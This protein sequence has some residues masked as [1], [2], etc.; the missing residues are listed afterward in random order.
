MCKWTMRVAEQSEWA[1]LP[2]LVV[3]RVLKQLQW[4][5]SASA[6]FRK[7]C[8]RWQEV[9]DGL[10][11]GLRV[12]SVPEAWRLGRRLGGVRKLDMRSCVGVSD[13]TI[14]TLASITHLTDLELY[15]CK[16][17]D[18]HIRM[19]AP[20]LINLAHL[21]LSNCTTVT[22]EG[23]RALSPLSS[24]KSLS[25]ANCEEV[26]DEG[27]RAIAFSHAA[28]TRL[29]LANCKAITTD[30]LRALATLTTLGKLDLSFRKVTVEDLAV[31]AL[32]HSLTSLDLFACRVETCQGKPAAALTPLHSLTGLN[33]SC[34]REL[35]DEGLK[36]LVVFFPALTQLR[37]DGCSAVTSSGVKALTTLSSL[38]TLNLSHCRA[39]SEAGVGL[40]A[41]C[42]G[43][44]SLDLVSSCWN[45]GDCKNM[46]A[47]ASLTNLTALNLQKCC[48]AFTYEGMRA[49]ASL[50]SLTSL[51]LS[52][53]LP[54]LEIIERRNKCKTV[55]CGELRVFG[56]DMK[57]SNEATLPPVTKLTCVDNSRRTMVQYSHGLGALMDKGI[58][59]FSGCR[60]AAEL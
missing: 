38:H 1:F 49:L 57:C 2:E 32:V 28:L 6:A 16:I 14:S 58:L 21:D 54:A 55:A 17:T 50:S 24:L 3:E 40:L 29:N 33:V 35:T 41:G 11:V 10:L 25:L 27:V 23:V 31:L 7:V 19:I 4:D 45:L 9:H 60:Q 52:A 30:G 44:R 26:T 59:C 5:R 43:L 53:S 37:M 8:R 51:K 48:R 13:Q 12:K 56:L 20:K 36:T 15:D 46:A 39:I 47:L 22:D 42:K 34:S 18:V